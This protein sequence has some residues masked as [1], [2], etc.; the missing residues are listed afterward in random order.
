VIEGSL[1][2]FDADHVVLDTVKMAEDGSKT[3]VVRFYEA[4]GG[5][6]LVKVSTGCL[7]IKQVVRC[8]ILEDVGEV[9]P[10]V[11]GAF[12]FYIKPFQLVSLRVSV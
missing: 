2:N 12:E 6:G 9:V 5:R 3:I 8:N 4:M 10:V 7:E 1:F 11:D